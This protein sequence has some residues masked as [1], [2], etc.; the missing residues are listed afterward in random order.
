MSPGTTVI[1]LEAFGARIGVRAPES[2]APDLSLRLPPRANISTSS[3]FD[4][5]YTIENAVLDSDGEGAVY[6][7]WRDEEPL[8]RYTTLDSVRLTIESDMHFRVALAARGF[9]FVH[10][11]VVERHGRVIVIPGRT[12]A[13]K[14]SLVM[15]LVRAGA[16][17]YSDEYAVIDGDG[18]IHPYRKPLSERVDG[19]PSIRLHSPESLGGP[20]DAR[21]RPM[22][23]ALITR[24]RP[25]ARWDPEPVSRAEALMA[26][27]E[28]TVVAR[29]RPSF[30]LELLAKA[31][32]DTAALKGDRPEAEDT[33]ASLLDVLH[34]LS[35]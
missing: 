14:S 27:F 28:N 7:V 10:A 31:V 2:I 23:L 1:S 8:G 4:A 24:Y 21:A 16:T 30:A 3:A 15:A 5:T 18:L 9:L 20:G 25:E 19:E 12:L 6:D 33:A 26:L 11:G 34:P 13:G 22:G 35:R 32:K 29:E 17:Y